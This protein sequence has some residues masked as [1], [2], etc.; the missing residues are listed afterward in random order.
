MKHGYCFGVDPC[1]Y[2]IQDHVKVVIWPRYYTYI[3][4]T[5]IIHI[6]LYA[7]LIRCISMIQSL[8]EYQIKLDV[9]MNVAPAAV[10][11]AV[12]EYK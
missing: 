9:V 5:H 3:C 12:R 8:I 10:V 1:V 7:Y 4:S 6:T 2:D 11:G